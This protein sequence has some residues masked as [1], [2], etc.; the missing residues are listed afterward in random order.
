M[1]NSAV[2][3]MEPD[4]GSWILRIE[5]PSEQVPEPR[6]DHQHIDVEDPEM[7]A[8]YLRQLYELVGPIKSTLVSYHGRWTCPDCGEWRLAP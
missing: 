7:A 2:P 5:V 3:V 8:V 1:A 6:S 4:T